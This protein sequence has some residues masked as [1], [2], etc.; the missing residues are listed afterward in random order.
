MRWFWNPLAVLCFPNCE[1][2][3]IKSRIKLYIL[4]D[5]FLHGNPSEMSW[6]IHFCFQSTRYYSNSN[7]T[8]LE[9]LLNAPWTSSHGK[10]PRKFHN[11]LFCKC[12]KGWKT[13]HCSIWVWFRSLIQIFVFR[14]ESVTR[15]RPLSLSQ[16]PPRRTVSLKARVAPAFKTFQQ[17]QDEGQSLVLSCRFISTWKTHSAER[18]SKHSDCGYCNHFTFKQ[19]SIHIFVF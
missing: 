15:T 8:S 3:R 13:I 9:V 6:G 11:L 1:E 19:G 12:G 16:S 7:K 5:V 10:V 14:F 4:L 17:C 18:S 2:P